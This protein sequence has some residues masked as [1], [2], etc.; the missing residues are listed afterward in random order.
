MQNISN[1]TEKL[2]KYGYGLRNSEVYKRFYN[3][4]KKSPEGIVFRLLELVRLGKRDEAFYVILREFSTAQ[5][6]IGLYLV[7]AFNPIYPDD[8]FKT[9]IY[10]FLS[11]LLGKKLEK[12]GK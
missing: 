7:K 10:S 1:M 2:T 8:I 3:I 11:G 9:F 4:D 5:E 6:E 12:G